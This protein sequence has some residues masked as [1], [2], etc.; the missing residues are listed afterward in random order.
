MRVVNM[1]PYSTNTANAAA[2]V[3]E[4]HQLI[5]LLWSNFTLL[6]W[7]FLIFDIAIVDAAATTATVLVTVEDEAYMVEC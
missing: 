4:D 6:S 3:N 2:T 1:L 7:I 5:A